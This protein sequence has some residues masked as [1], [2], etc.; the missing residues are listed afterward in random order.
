MKRTVPAVL[1]AAALDAQAH[2]LPGAAGTAA[3]AA[4]NVEPWLVACLAASAALYAVGVLRLWRRAGRGHGIGTA[5]VV[6]FALGWLALAAAL[7][8]P[9][10]ALGEALFWVHMVEHEILMVVA[11]PLLVTARPLEAWTWALPFSWRGAVARV[12]RAT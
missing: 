6:R 7:V 9:I 12:G 5:A 4:W 8:S 1:G 10:D 11:A 3:F 2:H